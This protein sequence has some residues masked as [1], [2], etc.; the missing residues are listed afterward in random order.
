MHR[1]A[2]VLVTHNLAVVVTSIINII[3]VVYYY[4]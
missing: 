2:L 3:N 4:G 1:L